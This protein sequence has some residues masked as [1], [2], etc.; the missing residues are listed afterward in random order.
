MS[1]KEYGKG[2]TLEDLQAQ[3][4]STLAMR[5]QVGLALFSNREPVPTPSPPPD[6]GRMFANMVSPMT[7]IERCMANMVSTL[8]SIGAF[9]NPFL[10]QIPDSRP[11]S[12]PNT[13][14]ARPVGFFG[15]LPVFEDKDAPRG[16]GPLGEFSTESRSG[17]GWISTQ[18][19]WAKPTPVPEQPTGRFQNLDFDQ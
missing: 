5:R 11:P 19:G 1:K 17:G 18:V 4:E 13:V 2:F 3:R 6:T 7:R 14:M 12:F 9:P 10:P 8:E 16:G 15:G